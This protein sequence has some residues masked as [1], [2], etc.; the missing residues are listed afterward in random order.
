M[1]RIFELHQTVKAP[2]LIVQ[3][4]GPLTAEEARKLAH[5]LLF[6]AACIEQFGGLAERGRDRV[7]DG[8]ERR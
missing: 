1:H 5:D 6:R 7:S 3:V 2:L 8:S 4:D